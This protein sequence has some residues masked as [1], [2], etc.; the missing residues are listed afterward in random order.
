MQDFVLEVGKSD[1]VGGS[2]FESSIGHTTCR[3]GGYD[4]CITYVLPW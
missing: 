3:R 1:E 4:G 2:V